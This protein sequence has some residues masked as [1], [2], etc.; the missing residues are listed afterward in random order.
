M[1]AAARIVTST[2]SIIAFTGCRAVIVLHPQM[3]TAGA[4]V[5]WL[6]AIAY[7]ALLWLGAEAA[8]NG[9]TGILRRR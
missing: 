1:K 6:A 9:P 7:A 2:G 5:C 3:S 8:F 4:V